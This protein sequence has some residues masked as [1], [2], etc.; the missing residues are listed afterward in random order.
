[1]YVIYEIESTYIL[2]ARAR[3]VGCY[4]TSYKT[5]GAAKAALTRLEK[6]GLLGEKVVQKPTAENNWER[7]TVPMTKAEFAIAE[8]VEFREK[9]EKKVVRKNLM[10][11]EEFEEALNT[12]NYCSP[13]SEA[14]WSM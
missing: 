6:K 3:S 7:K 12:P 5:E 2:K 9:I 10:S 11:G 13:A 1:M 14:Y 8:A 4:V